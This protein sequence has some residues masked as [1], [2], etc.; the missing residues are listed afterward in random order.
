MKD[1]ESFMKLKNKILKKNLKVLCKKYFELMNKDDRDFF[2]VLDNSDEYKKVINCLN[3]DKVIENLFYKKLR[4]KDHDIYI[5]GPQEIIEDFL[6]KLGNNTKEF[7]KKEFDRFY[8]SFE[9]FLYDNYLEVAYYIHLYNYN[10]VVLRISLSPDICIRKISDEEKREELEENH[11]GFIFSSYISDF[12]IEIKDKLKKEI[13]DD[14]NISYLNNFKEYDE[15]NRIFDIALNSLRILK[16]SSVFLSARNIV[17]INAFTSQSNK[18]TYIT[19]NIKPVFVGAICQITKKEIGQLKDVFNF[20]Y[21][22]LFKIDKNKDRR[23]LR[24]A[25][26]RL[27]DGITRD[28]LIDRLIDYM[29]GLEALFLPDAE[30][31]LKYRL[32]IRI[33]FNLEKE[34]GKRKKLYDDMKYFYNERSKGVHGDTGNLKKEDVDKVEE[35]LRKSILTWKANKDIFDQENL[36]Y[37]LFK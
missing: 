37:G 17:C 27:N 18:V 6:N 36:N 19:T 22:N 28:S 7:K 20:V 26:T 25:I 10:Q 21:K 16:K 33:A 31:E 23:R 9:S 24:I 4:K 34:F 15:I 2:K 5:G 1:F 32:T 3:S 29:I 11:S 30:Q 35:I 14:S 8:S 13:N 12:V